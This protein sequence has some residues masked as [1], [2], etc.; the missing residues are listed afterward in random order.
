[1]GFEFSAVRERRV[2]GA[3]YK[4]MPWLMEGKPAAWRAGL[5]PGMAARVAGG[6][7]PLPSSR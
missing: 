1:M 6:S 3:L 2:T 5:N 4:L 7:T